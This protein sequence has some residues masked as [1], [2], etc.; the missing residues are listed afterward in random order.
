MSPRIAVFVATSGHSGVDRAMQHLIPAIARR[1][2]PIDLL[3]VPRHGPN[4]DPASPP[5]TARVIELGSKH[6]YSSLPGFRPEPY[7]L[8]AHAGVVAT[9]AYLGALGLP[10][11]P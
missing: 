8:L 3:H 7:D 6:V 5:H 9:D 4:L 1:G 2:C 10:T 11:T